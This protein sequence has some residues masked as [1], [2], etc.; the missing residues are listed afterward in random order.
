MEINV[1]IKLTEG[2]KAAW[3]LAHDTTHV[4]YLV[5]CYSRQCGK[6][7][8]CQLLMI[9]YLCKPDTFN[10]YI[11]PTFQLGR[12][13]YKEMI[14]LL[15]PSG[16]IKKANST[17]LTIE[18]V[19][20]STLQFFSAEAYTAIRGHTVSGILIL[21]EAAYMQDELPNGENFWGNVVMPIC[22]ARKPLVVMVSTPCGT[23]GFFYEFY[24]R[25]LNHFWGTVSIKRTI[26]D[27]QLL[28]E[29]EIEEIKNSISDTA[30]R[31]EFL[32]EFLDDGQT[33][34]TGFAE[35]FDIQS[36]SSGKTW[37][38]IDLA[39]DGQDA[40]IVTLINE[41]NEVQQHKISGTLDS[42]YKQ[43]ADL[44]NKTSP[45][46]VYAEN[47]G[48]GAPMINEIRK[49][50]RNRGAILEWTTTNSTKEEIVS[51]LAVEIANKSIHFQKDDKELFKELQNFAVTISKS[52]KLTFMGKHGV[53]DD[54]VMSL[55]IALRCKQDMKAFRSNNNG[56]V[57]S[58]H[59]S[60][61]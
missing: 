46:A 13:V 45:T 3:D 2:Q 34:F 49:L 58:S 43:I 30:F 55:A 53:H 47:N 4:R 39:G 40:T 21:D 36:F 33:F 18:T 48:L 60:I 50:V 37:M 38:G 10:A 5:M 22:K 12:K 8:L 6:S 61:Y 27:D 44:I 20:N 59:R 16:I 29:Q 51:A 9:E 35:C 42:K 19:F 24:N 57:M 23:S 26:Y 52:R 15:E 28:T 56:F 17:T 7:V 31:Q 32:C 41:K 25:G 1:D 54:R 14:Q 11:S